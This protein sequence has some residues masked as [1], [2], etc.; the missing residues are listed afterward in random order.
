MGNYR[1]Q[2]PKKSLSKIESFV[3]ESY[4]KAFKN[5]LHRYFYVVDYV[6]KGTAYY[7]KEIPV[8]RKTLSERLN[9]S[10]KD[11]TKILKDLCDLG[12]IQKRQEAISG[13]KSAKYSLLDKSQS[14]YSIPVNINSSKAVLS[15]IQKRNNKMKNKIEFQDTDEA[16]LL[17]DYLSLITI[18]TSILNDVINYP[19]FP[20]LF[21]VPN[22][23]EFED[24]DI[25]EFKLEYGNLLRIYHKDLY[26]KRPVPKSRIYTPFS[27]MHREHRKYLTYE[28]K[29][30]K[31]IDLV[32]SQPLL[33]S[34]FIYKYCTD[35]GIKIPKELDT[36]KKS[37]EQG[38]FYEQFMNE[39]E[40]KPENR[41]AF[42]KDFF[43]SVFFTKV[44]KMKNRLR[45]K[46]IS[47]Y[48]EIHKLLDRIKTEYGND[49]FAHQMQMFEASI[50]W[51]DVNV[52]M[53]K[54]G[55]LCYNIYDSIVSHDE[56]TL[57][58]ATR[59]IIHAFKKYDITP[60]IKIEDFTKY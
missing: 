2:I 49:G 31:C 56:A 18:N 7:R 53:L 35:N 37:C 36:Y 14:V 28:G 21:Y 42:K 29:T 55:Y 47:I 9:T 27:V 43:G 45:D 11:T 26:I 20:F 24:E 60:S 41:T 17:M 3:K 10:G 59:R 23:G 33:S 22:V 44:S 13:T 52:S 38:K 57:A 25:L 19:L 5:Y 12:V 48:P 32:N 4:P 39:E 16:S 30:L 51:D 58:E 8:N 46:F 15:I 6:V 40:N 54:D 1:F 34:A 50:I